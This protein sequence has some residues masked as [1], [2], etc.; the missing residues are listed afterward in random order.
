MFNK[1]TR[2][3]RWNENRPELVFDGDR[4]GI[5]ELYG[6]RGSGDLNDECKLALGLESVVDEDFDTFSE[7][8]SDFDNSDDSE[9]DSIAVKGSRLLLGTEITVL[10]S[11]ARKIQSM[12][13]QKCDFE[14]PTP[15]CWC[16][17]NGKKKF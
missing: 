17:F 6:A 1:R 14:L 3:A 7:D 9:V 10:A 16:E 2:L 11:T 4:Q 15:K 13:E 8:S 12:P 5:I